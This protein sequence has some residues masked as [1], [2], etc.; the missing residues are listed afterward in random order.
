[1]WK[2]GLYLS[3][4]GLQARHLDQGLLFFS[5]HTLLENY[6]VD[7]S[8]RL[9]NLISSFQKIF[10]NTYHPRTWSLASLGALMWWLWSVISKIDILNLGL[11]SW[12][13]KKKK[14]YQLIKQRSVNSTTTTSLPP[15]NY[16]Y[17]IL[18]IPDKYYDR[19][20]NLDWKREIL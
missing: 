13:G 8:V 4:P 20:L 2:K 19:D 11:F 7:V 15:I 12:C 6:F 10:Y 18:F 9:V 17:T 14:G 16:N 5:V 1:M 3:Y